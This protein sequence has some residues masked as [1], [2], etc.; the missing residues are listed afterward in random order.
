MISSLLSYQVSNVF[1]KNVAIAETVGSTAVNA[2]NV[3]GEAAI[4]FVTSVDVEK[5]INETEEAVIRSKTALIKGAFDAKRGAI[6]LLAKAKEDH[7]VTINSSLNGT[8]EQ[9]SIDGMQH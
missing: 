1:E 7:K 3:G 2:V 8:R 9:L 4:D 6:R 5:A